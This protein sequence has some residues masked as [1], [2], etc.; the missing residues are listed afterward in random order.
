MPARTPQP[1]RSLPG[2]HTTPEDSSV[3]D[4]LELPRDRD[5]AVDMTGGGTND[6]LIE[7][8]ARD[9]NEGRQ[10]TSKAIEMDRTYKKL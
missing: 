5:E 10:D 1:Q 2:Q 8:A 3:E 9:V 6:P 7:Q 4:S